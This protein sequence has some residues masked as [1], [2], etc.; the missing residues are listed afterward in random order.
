MEAGAVPQNWPAL[1]KYSPEQSTDE[2]FSL[3]ETWSTSNSDAIADTVNDP[4]AIV[5]PDHSNATPPYN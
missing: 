4:F 3:A 1:V 2:Y 5:V